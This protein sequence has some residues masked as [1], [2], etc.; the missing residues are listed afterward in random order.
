MQT[1]ASRRLP[2]L[3]N[4]RGNDEGVL[5][6][7]SRVEKRGN[8]HEAWGWPV[9]RGVW[10]NKNGGSLVAEVRDALQGAHL[11]LEDGVGALLQLELLSNLRDDAGGAEAEPQFGTECTCPNQL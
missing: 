1:R 5:S 6:D 3:L 2:V 9:Y 10:I 8:G 11:A 7:V 4:L